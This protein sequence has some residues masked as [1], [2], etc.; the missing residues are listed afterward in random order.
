[1]TVAA[2]TWTDSASAIRRWSTSP[3]GAS[4]L[5]ACAA[6]L[7]YLITGWAG[8]EWP[9]LYIPLADALLHGRADV[10]AETGGELAPIGSIW[11]VPFPPAPAILYMPLV[12]WL[13]PTPGIGYVVPAVA[14]GMSVGLGHLLLRRLDVALEPSLWLTA[15]FA[16]TT[17][18]W[19]ATEGGTWH[20]A[21]VLAVLFSLAALHLALSA[22]WPL[23]AGLLLGFAAA[24]RLPVGLSLP[25]FLY[26]YRGSYARIAAL[27]AG[28]GL[29]AVLVGMYNIARFNSPLDFGYSLIPSFY[30]PGGTVLDE[31]WFRDGIISLSYIPRSLGVMF[32]S[33]FQIVPDAPYLKPSISGLSILLSAPIYLFAIR[34]PRSQ[35]TAVAWLAVVLVML[36]NLAHGSWG[37]W[38]LGYRFLL[39]ATPFLLVLLGLTFRDHIGLAARAAVVLGAAVTGY[40]LWAMKLALFVDQGLPFAP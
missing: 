10:P 25:L 12:G 21:Q 11:Y 9:D 17:L 14:G 2:T 23:A 20:V 28:I 31:S 22:R 40:G 35:F 15:G 37:F 33:G 36:P 30:H 29:L 13:G 5:L 1:M 27:L 8:R 24:S 16:T 7:L 3:F 18:W 26:L 39:D 38:Q 32:L 34:A 4:L 19:V 6:T